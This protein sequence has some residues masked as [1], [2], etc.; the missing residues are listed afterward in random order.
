MKPLEEGIEKIIR[1][2]GNDNLLSY[3]LSMAEEIAEYVRTRRTEMTT[4]QILEQT[5]DIE[6]IAL[7][8]AYERNLKIV[9]Q[10]I[11]S[12]L[13]IKLDLTADYEKQYNQIG[14]KYGK[15]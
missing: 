7:R 6:E 15:K 8:D 11:N 2:Y 13:D 3:S 1:S 9:Q 4:N 5:R 10:C 14:K 12:V